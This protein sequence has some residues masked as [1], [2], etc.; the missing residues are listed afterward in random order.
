M[1]QKFSSYIMQDWEINRDTS[2]KS[3]LTLV[4]FRTAQIFNK[5]PKP[6]AIPYKLLYQFIVEWILGVEL[7]WDTQIG[8]NLKLHHGYA[9]VINHHVVIGTNCILR[10]STT[11]GNKKLADGRFSSSP[12]IGNNV[13]IGCQVVILGDV[14]VGD[15]AVIGAG[16]VVVKNVPPGAVVVGNPARI[17]R[18]GKTLEIEELE[19]ICS[20]CS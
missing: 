2:L 14:T 5:L 19:N 17:L 13:E 7:P 10:H 18:M 1:I 6:L 8:A 20:S 15:N 9:L 4:L 11:I 12:K 16:S 3:Q